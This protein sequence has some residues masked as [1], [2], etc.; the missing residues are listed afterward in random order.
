M[1]GIFL[2]STWTL[3][4]SGKMRA[5]D[6]QGPGEI[7]TSIN[8]DMKC[9][10]TQKINMIESDFVIYLACM[11]T[12]YNLVKMMASAKYRSWINQIGFISQHD[13]SV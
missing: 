2:A 9:I 7:E 13:T 5:R 11:R 3:Y 6:S 4:N 1:T 10:S 8:F 12:F